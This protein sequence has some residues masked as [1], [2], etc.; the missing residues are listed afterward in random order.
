MYAAGTSC[1]LPPLQPET[2]PPTPTLSITTDQV[3]WEFRK[4]RT[5]RATGPD[6]TITRLL[7]DAADQLSGMTANILSLSLDMVPDL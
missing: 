1:S 3:M 5:K 4:S 6:R 7:R 2:C